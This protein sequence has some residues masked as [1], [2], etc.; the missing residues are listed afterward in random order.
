VYIHNAEKQRA[1]LAPYTCNEERMRLFMAATWIKP[2]HIH[3][4][5]SDAGVGD[6]VEYVT[7]YAKTKD[8]A[9]VTAYNCTVTQTA[10]DFEVV[11][12]E[13]QCMTNKK[14]D[15]NEILA[16]HVRQAFKPGEIDPE[17]ANKLG[18][19]LAMELT[20]GKH[21]Y[22]VA[23]HTDKEHIHNHIIINA[24]E[25][26]ARNKF[27]NPIRSYKH[28]RKISDKICDEHNLSVIENP[29]LSKSRAEEYL[30]RSARPES[31]RSILMN[32]IDEIILNDNPKT[33]N[34][35]CQRLKERSYSIKHRGKNISVKPN[36]GEHYI[37]LTE[38]TLKGYGLESLQAKIDARNNERQIKD[39][40]QN[41]N[42]DI[43]IHKDRL[44]FSAAKKYNDNE[45]LRAKF[46]LIIDIEN[47]FEAQLSEG[48][49]K[50]VQIYN[51]QQAAEM[52]IFL[53]NNNLT[54]M[55]ALRK[56]VNEEESKVADVQTKITTIGKKLKEISTLQRYIGA[57]KKTSA[58]YSQYLRSKRNRDFYSKN[59]KEIN[60]CEEAKKYFDSLGLEEIPDYNDLKKEYAQLLKEVK[61]MKNQNY[62]SNNKIRDIKKALGNATI[63][64]NIEPE[65]NDATEHKTKTENEMST[66]HEK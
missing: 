39:E 63:L 12:H 10:K 32:D 66:P 54:N 38:K 2:I 41:K 36:N 30:Y 19:L 17:A 4:N 52:L 3:R 5:G 40:Q 61:E 22:I 49:K 44:A 31:K 42:E 45:Y 16:Y 13:Y 50:W 58:V 7:D 8:G 28:L 35:I 65:V 24:Y 57:Y 33:I 53:Q 51:L 34:E 55:G 1:G 11:R 43:K 47:C 56:A 64:L 18:H 23:T 21:Q 14:Q 60:A 6:A 29:A 37:R 26:E 20:K 59:E 48:Y 25:Y 46:K 62:Q 9:L 15:E 27:R